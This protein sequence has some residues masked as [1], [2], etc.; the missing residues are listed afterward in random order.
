MKK[1]L[2]ISLIFI[3]S[4][5]SAKTP[6][7]VKNP[8]KVYPSKDFFTAVGSGKNQQQ[9]ELA[10][11]ENL[12]AIFGRSVRSSAKTSSRMQQA[13]KDGTV[14]VGKNSDFSQSITQK[15]AVEDLIGIELKEY[16]AD[17]K[18]HYALAVMDKKETE[19]ILVASIR[20]NDAKV[21]KLVCAKPSDLYSLETY[22]RYD[23]AREIASLDEKMLSK[24]EVI[25]SDTAKGLKNIYSSASV[26]SQMLDIA[27]MIP[28]YLNIEGDL[29]GQIKQYVSE[30]FS[31][32]GFRVSDMKEERYGFT[33]TADFVQR[34]PD[35][36][37]TVQCLYSFK[38][39][40]KDVNFLETMWAVSFE[41][42]ESST[43]EKGLSRR[44]SKALAS[45][46][47][48]EVFSSFEGFL[49]SLRT[50]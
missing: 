8:S 25:N 23:Y 5:A 42:R 50:E 15:V 3:A 27:K 41:G 46:V 12:A 31:Q 2:L 32:F 40:L 28:I 1:F 11:V 18:K 35:D 16:Y 43:E 47:S 45:K 38:G 19:K 34:I 6:Q 36:K 33:G 7:W 17:E 4:L 44:I 30:M 29:D 21:E 10:A 20:A 13:Q 24:L 49:S 26:R 37:K 22:A 39:Q 48:G 14:S 9:A